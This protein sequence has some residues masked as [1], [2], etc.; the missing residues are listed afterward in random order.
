MIKTTLIALV[1]IVVAVNASAADL[2]TG[3]S[4]TSPKSATA[5]VVGLLKLNVSSAEVQEHA[6][7]FTELGK[8]A[9]PIHLGNSSSWLKAA[10]T[11]VPRHSV[12]A[13][14]VNEAA[15]T[16][17]SSL[18]AFFAAVWAN[19]SKLVIYVGVII[20]ILTINSILR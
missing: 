14:S 19:W 1:G 11:D 8:Q 16:V 12:P 15:G 7:M 2:S 6:R 9:T 13:P 18:G 3:G 5:P 4:T 20:G 17:V 10:T